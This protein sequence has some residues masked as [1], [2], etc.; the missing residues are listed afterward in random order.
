MPRCPLRVEPANDCRAHDAEIVLDCPARNGDR[1]SSSHNGCSARNPTT[2][3]RAAAF[4]H[5]PVELPHRRRLGLHRLGG[6]LQTVRRRRSDGQDSSALRA[7]VPAPDGRAG[8]LGPDARGAGP[9]TRGP[10]CQPSGVLERGFDEGGGAHASS[11]ASRSRSDCC[12]AAASSGLPAF[13]ASSSD[14]SISFRASSLRP[15][16]AFA[17]P[18]LP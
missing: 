10:V 11:A 7:G 16:S 13:R 8:S 1:R 17:I 15:R 4:R 12:A 9:S 14:A 2:R 3:L 18:R 6:P 5:R